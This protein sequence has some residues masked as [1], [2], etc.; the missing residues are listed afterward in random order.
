[1]SGSQLR[2]VFERMLA[3]SPLKLEYR[4]E[5]MT[6]DGRLTNLVPI[7][8]KLG[9]GRS[10][11]MMDP[12]HRRAVIFSLPGGNVIVYERFTPGALKKYTLSVEMPKEFL[13]HEVFKGQSVNTEDILRLYMHCH[14]LL[15]I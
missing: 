1:M 14:R 7:E 15:T 10:A 4:Q 2:A 11:R 6:N 3:N 12:A 13:K 5:Y 8:L 9:L